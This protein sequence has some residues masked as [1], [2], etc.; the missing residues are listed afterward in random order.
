MFGFVV[1]GIGFRVFGFQSF[2]DFVLV[3]SG[4]LKASRRP[5][6][7]T[8]SGHVTRVS[9]NEWAQDKVWVEVSQ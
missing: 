9:G 2:K 5:Y 8:C 4:H 6:L 1:L 3:T 7:P